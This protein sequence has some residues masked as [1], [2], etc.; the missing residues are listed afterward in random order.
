MAR[1]LGRVPTENDVTTDRPGLLREIDLA[2]VTRGAAF[3]RAKVV[4]QASAV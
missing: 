2:Y 1:K 4:L 3:K